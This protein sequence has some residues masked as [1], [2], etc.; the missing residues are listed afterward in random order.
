MNAGIWLARRSRT[1][2]RTEI[3]LNAARR[4]PTIGLVTTLSFQQARLIVRPDLSC[5]I[6][7]FTRTFTVAAAV[8][9][10]ARTT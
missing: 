4:I 1:I 10:N 3:C 6:I 5:E 7:Y 8:L 2:G 9:L